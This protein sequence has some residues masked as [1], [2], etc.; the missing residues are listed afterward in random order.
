MNYIVF[1]H[2]IKKNWILKGNHVADFEGLTEKTSE[3]KF[4][5]S[6]D[7][8][9]GKEPSDI[10]PAAVAGKLGCATLYFSALFVMYHDRKSN[11]LRLHKVC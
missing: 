6:I 5:A 3:F 7:Y 11:F 8:Y 1:R 4:S 2:E 9:V 10:G